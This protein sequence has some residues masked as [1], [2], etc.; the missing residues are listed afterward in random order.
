MKKILLGIAILAVILFNGSAYILNQTEQALI[1]QFG[2]PI[3]VVNP[4]GK[5]D[6]GLHFKLPYMLQT[7]KKFDKRV[8]NLNTEQNEF[9]A[10][11]SEDSEKSS[12]L[13]LIDAVSQ[14]KDAQKKAKEKESES[15]TSR[16]KIDAYA[17]YTITDPLALYNSRVKTIGVLNDKLNEILR[18]KLSDQITKNSLRN[19]LTD[20]RTE[21]ISSVQE[22]LNIEAATFGV[23]IVDVKLRRADLPTINYN[24][25]INRMRAE[26]E[27]EAREFRAQGAEQAQIITST[28][29]K[30]R[31]ILLANA[32]KKSDILRGE[33]EAQSTRIFAESFGKDVN[34]YTF[35][36]SMQAYKETLGEKDTTMV[37]SPDSEFLRYFSDIGGKKK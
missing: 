16:I 5:N 3:E 11:G 23:Q 31:T 34:F 24:H 27:K 29:D 14:D 13:Q 22:S 9:T 20:K 32:Q 21:I 36:R 18:S 28:A 37:L 30:E 7:V 17:K 33:G 4:V 2:N 15:N 35:Y 10:F 12:Q 19:L 8:L 25:V 26:R 6:P 1:L